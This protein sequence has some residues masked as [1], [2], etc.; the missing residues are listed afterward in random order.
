[1][2]TTIPAIKGQFTISKDLS[3]LSLTLENF[4]P[5]PWSIVHKSKLSK[6][7]C[8]AKNTNNTLI[9]KKSNKK[10]FCYKIIYVLLPS[11]DQTD[12]VK[13]S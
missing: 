12:K 13:S 3:I 1:M 8:L 4:L 7:I 2:R 9:E 6:V 10:T 11:K 5:I